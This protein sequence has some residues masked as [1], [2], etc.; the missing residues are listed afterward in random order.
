MWTRTLSAGKIY[1]FSEEHN[2]HSSH[3]AVDDTLVPESP[4]QSPNSLPT[5]FND[6]GDYLS[7]PDDE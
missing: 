6:A 3:A 1:Y 2:F 4:F 7:A 5:Y